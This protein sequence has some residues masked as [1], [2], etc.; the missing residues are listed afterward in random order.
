MKRWI[1]WVVGTGLVMIAWGVAA[2]TPPEEAREAP[3]AIRVAIGEQATGRNIEVTVTDIRRASSI[4]AGTWHADGNWVVVDL[5]AAA[6]I[7]DSPASLRLA[8]LTID[9]T[10]YR[11]SE[12]PASFLDRALT[13][14]IPQS[15]SLA[16]E[17]QDALDSG[18]ATLTLGLNTD[19][20]LDSIVVVT[21]QLEDVKVERETALQVTG[22][23]R[24]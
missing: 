18:T 13:L 2:F 17:L 4:T 11:A 5:T 10:I 24:G 16:F 8:T 19:P 3:F 15:G 9:G 20:R 7:T 12:R 6:V 14:G 22:W 1:Q 23:A 21:T